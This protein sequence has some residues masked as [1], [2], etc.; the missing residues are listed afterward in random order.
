MIQ[1]MWRH[2]RPYRKA[3]SLVIVLLFVQAIAN[4]YLPDLNADIINNGVVAGDIPYIWRTGA[5]MVLVAALLGFGSIVSVYWGSKTAMAFG[6]DLRVTMFRHV[7]SFSQTELSQFGAPSL[8]TRCTND[9]QQVQMMVVMVLNVMVLAPIMAV[10]G[11]FMAMR[12]DVP[13]STTLAVIIPLMAV[14]MG[15]MLRTVIPL[16]GTMQELVDR[17]NLVMREKLTGVR[18]IRAFVRTEFEESRFDEANRELTDTQ[19]RV[20]QTFALMIPSLMFIFNIS[21]V[22][23]LWFGAYRVDSGAMPIGNLTAFLA[24]LMQI[25]MSVM[26]AVM[27]FVIVPRAAVSLRRIKEVLDTET[28]VR[29]S[30]A[31]V[32]ME[33]L[34]GHIEF[35]DVEFRYPGAQDAVLDKIS[36]S[37][38]PGETVAFIG[39][40]GSGKT[41]LVNLIPRFYDVTGGRIT[42]DGVDV[43]DLSLDR[44]WSAIGFVQQ[45]AFLFNGTVASNL[46]YGKADASEDELWHA[47]DVAQ[48]KAFVAKMDEGLDAPITQGGGNVSGGQRQRLTIARALVKRPAIYVFDD[49]FSALDAQTD[50]RLRAALAKEGADKTVLI[51]TQRV[52]TVM[53]ASRIVVLDQGKVVG[54]G[55]HEALLESCETYREI[56]YSQMSAEEA[57]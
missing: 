30:V 20:V 9:V 27:L 38:R 44:L 23:I 37:A 33:E 56:V 11:I 3:L 4:L 54:I 46:R 55:R 21:S 2:L 31:P 13:L 50:A 52:S 53:N 28:S 45:K 5:I 1:L 19:L 41:T 6:R 25:L 12:Q 49:S 48:G 51:V 35:H 40:T 47:L 15:L 43:R 22:A 7:E 16:F 8:I 29:E 42:I 26:M 18:V 57:A 39:S 10:G 17:V 34:Q 24:Y 36:F 14:V 32:F